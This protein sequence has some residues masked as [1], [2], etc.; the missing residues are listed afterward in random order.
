MCYDHSEAVDARRRG[1]LDGSK[2]VVEPYNFFGLSRS[3][4]WG[5][6]ACGIHRNILT[7]KRL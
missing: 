3:S 4:L 6:N 2:Q 1:Y 5:K 7:L